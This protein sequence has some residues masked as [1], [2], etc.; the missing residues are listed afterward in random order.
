M[1]KD[2]TRIFNANQCVDVVD[3][4]ICTQNIRLF[5]LTESLPLEWK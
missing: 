1:I 4:N 5:G 3:P 2:N